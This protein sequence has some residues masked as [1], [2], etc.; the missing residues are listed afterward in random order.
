MSGWHS[1][2]GY[3][4]YK[5]GGSFQKLKAK[6][7]LWCVFEEKKCQ[8]LCYKNEQESLKGSPSDVM[9]IKDSAII[10]DMER[11]NQFI[12]MCKG[13]DYIF[14]AENHESMMIWVLGLQA[15]QRQYSCP[16][17]TGNEDVHDSEQ[18]S[19]D[20]EK[21]YNRGIIQTVKRSDPCMNQ[22]TDCISPRQP[23]KSGKN[24]KRNSSTFDSIIPASFIQK[25]SSSNQNEEDFKNSENSSFGAQNNK[26]NNNNKN[27]SSEAFQSEQTTKFNKNPSLQE[28]QNKRSKRNTITGETIRE[29]TTALN[30]TNKCS[31][32]KR[33]SISEEGY[34]EC[35]DQTREEE[36]EGELME[37]KCDLAKVLNTLTTYQETIARKDLIILQ[38]D[39]QV[40]ELEMGSQPGLK[41]FN[42]NIS[43]KMKDIQEHIRVLQNKNRF[44]NKEVHRLATLRQQDQMKYT[45][46]YDEIKILESEIYSCKGEYCLLVQSCIKLPQHEHFDESNFVL[47]NQRS[48]KEKVC[49]LLEEARRTNPSLPVYERL[50]SKQVHVD[51]YGFKQVHDT[52]D[53][54]IHYICQ[55]LTLHYNK[56]LENYDCNQIQW[57]LFCK[58]INTPT[59][60][61]KNRKKKK[62][63]K[64]LGR[65]GIPD[66]FRGKLWSH[67]IK[68]KME[69]LM[70]DKGLHYFSNLCN[71]QIDCQ[72]AAKY[73]R[74][75]LVD[76]LRTMPNNVKFSSA[77]SKG[78]M[79][80]QD[81]LLAYCVHNPTIGYCQGMNFFAAMCLLFMNAQDSF[82]ALV[83]ITECYFPKHYFDN[84]LIGAQADQFILRDLVRAILPN[85]ADHLEKRDIELSTITLT[86]F[87]AIFFDSVP[88]QTLLRIWDCFIIEGPKVLFRFSVAI[89][90]IHETEL[91]KQTDTIS[92]M[93]HVKS[94]AKLTIDIEELIKVAFEELNPFPKWQFIRAKQVY[95][96]SVLQEHYKWQKFNENSFFFGGDET[97]DKTNHLKPIAEQHLSI[98]TAEVYIEGFAWF[99]YGKQDYS[100]VFEINCFN[101]VMYE[102][103]IKFDTK[104]LCCKA[105]NSYDMILFGTLSSM[106]YAYDPKTRTKL[107]EVRLLSAALSLDYI[108]KEKIVSIFVGLSNGNIAIIED[109]SISPNSLVD[110]LYIPL[111][112]APISSLLVWEDTIWCASANRVFILS[113][114]TLDSISAFQLS[115]NPYEIVLSMKTCDQGIWISSKGSSFIEIWDPDSLICKMKYDIRNGWLSIP[116]EDDEKLNEQR[117][118]CFLPHYN[119]LWIGVGDGNLSIYDISFPPDSVKDLA[120][121][122]DFKKNFTENTA[123]FL[124]NNVHT[125]PT[126]KNVD[127]HSTETLMINKQE[128]NKEICRQF[129]QEN[130][131]L[132]VEQQISDSDDTVSENGTKSSEYKDPFLKEKF[133][134]RSRTILPD[135]IDNVTHRQSAEAIDLL[136]STN[137][138]LPSVQNA[139][140]DKFFYCNELDIKPRKETD[141]KSQSSMTELQ[142]NKM[143]PKISHK[144]NSSRILVKGG[145]NNNSNWN[146][147]MDKEIFDSTSF[148]N[149]KPETVSI[150]WSAVWKKQP[151]NLI[152][153]ANK[154]ENHAENISTNGTEE[155]EWKENTEKYE[156]MDIIE[157]GN[158]LN[159]LSPS[160]ESTWDYK[161][162]DNYNKFTSIDQQLQRTSLNSHRPSNNRG[163]NENNQIQTVSAASGMGS[164]QIS[165]KFVQNPTTRMN[166]VNETENPKEKNSNAV[167][168][169]YYE[170]K[171]R[172]EFSE[173]DVSNSKEILEHRKL[174][175][176]SNISELSSICATELASNSFDLSSISTLDADDLKIE[177]RKHSIFNSSVSSSSTTT[178]IPDSS[179][180]FNLVAR[181][182]IS[183]KPVVCLL[184][185]KINEEPFILSFSGIRGDEEPVL[186]WRKEPE[187]KIWTN[188]PVQEICPVTKIPKPSLYH[189]NYLQTNSQKKLFSNFEKHEDAT[190]SDFLGNKKK[191]KNSE[192]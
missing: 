17:C 152:L 90:K 93:K 173:F 117:V 19:Y 143:S 185:S 13:K 167:L 8:L 140:S 160:I 38:L 91:L 96:Q 26:N 88:F 23:E 44:L 100:V 76:L 105:V 153:L 27:N 161:Y 190:F 177:N 11:Q 178:D 103:P 9:N 181:L 74:Q 114:L 131:E 42:D 58:N 47:A 124:E 80:L 95:Y 115:T 79:D 134:I 40:E 182:K 25:T 169:D 78:I 150:M 94:C 142:T 37:T 189:R 57:N 127:K 1:L 36:L 3:L 186:K 174:S 162:K 49:K 6:K 184:E 116:K 154:L 163:D 191:N 50:M 45:D 126:L 175:F 172:L 138:H 2:S 68:L 85:L 34:P 51:S 16:C 139:S 4:H 133:D 18:N 107:W 75:V 106:L 15:K 108:I 63:L 7:K 188:E 146:H 125:I 30:E 56:Q 39:Q 155:K 157:N 55:Q 24:F 118:T 97:D 132:S 149:N 81:I 77:E 187:E 102:L 121:F 71:I 129:Y 41:K 82:W 20:K 171:Y 53:M 135:I 60:W 137:C 28:R 165:M 87:M 31:R 170:S 144:Y 104:V 69:N 72:S 112:Q 43:K 21:L 46:Q 70:S 168:Q 73:R 130:K 179:Y 156:K 159:N 65:K 66:Q 22:T 110:V 92:L 101:N 122:D 12:I 33:D 176:C 166:S 151:E 99:S 29:I 84:N 136:D 86:W 89:L 123:I 148:L 59:E 52:S 54:A 5:P 113:A 32:V 61:W 10:L 180:L 158:S 67:F 128:T 48:H 111:N 141:L 62:E 98:Q 192:P 64:L 14:C 83:A 183:E 164:D 109:P 120:S 147:S 145:E 119:M 35:K